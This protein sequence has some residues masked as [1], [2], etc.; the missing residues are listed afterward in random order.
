MDGDLQRHVLSIRS[1]D[2]INSS[3]A[4]YSVVEGKVVGTATANQ[5]ALAK[6]RAAQIACE[7]LGISA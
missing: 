7:G 3:E 4:L 6:E 1:L 5:K 2:R